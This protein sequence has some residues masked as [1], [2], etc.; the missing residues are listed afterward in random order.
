MREAI[1][2]H[3]RRSI[4]NTIRLCRGQRISQ[5]A[6]ADLSGLGIVTVNRGVLYLEAEGAISRQG[7]RQPS[8]VVHHRR[9]YELGYIFD[10]TY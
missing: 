5:Q 3:A 1:S 4:I 9:A 7:K 10:G 2:L 6:L 8:Y